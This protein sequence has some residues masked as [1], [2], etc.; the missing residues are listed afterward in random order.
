MIWCHGPC[1]CLCR[2][3]DLYLLHTFKIRMHISPQD[4]EKDIEIDILTCE[5][6]VSAFAKGHQFLERSR[7]SY[8]HF[9][10][11]A[12][13]KIWFPRMCYLDVNVCGLKWDIA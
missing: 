1:G 9:Q 10:T 11:V 6:P 2:H 7:A 4:T 12:F 3:L 13:L 8:L 5:Q